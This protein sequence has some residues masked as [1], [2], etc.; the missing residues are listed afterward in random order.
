MIKFNCKP[1]TV[2]EYTNGPHGY[3]CTLG[4][5]V[6]KPS[7]AHRHWDTT[8]ADL[9]VQWLHGAAGQGT[10][11]TGVA[12]ARARG[13]EAQESASPL[14]RA[15]NSRPMNYLFPEFSI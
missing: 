6:S 5:L 15:C 10:L 9:T 14:S 2:R 13:G 11:D 3:L 1:G 12:Q 7:D 8:T 4:R